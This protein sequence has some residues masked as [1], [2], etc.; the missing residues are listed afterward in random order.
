MTGA[1]SY[2]TDTNNFFF[3]QFTCTQDDDTLNTKY[4]QVNIVAICGLLSCFIYYISLHFLKRD[5]KLNRMGWDVQTITLAD[6][7]VELGIS[8]GAY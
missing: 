3:L 5:S 6:Y 4:G 2:C 7:S 1:P 8:E